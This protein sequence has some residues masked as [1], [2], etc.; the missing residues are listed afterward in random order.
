MPSLPNNS[1]MNNNAYPTAIYNSMI[2]PIVPYGIKGAIWYQG[3]S[4]GGEGDEYFHKMQALIG[5][6]RKIWNEGDFPFYFVQ[7]ANFQDATNNPMGGDGWARVRMAQTKS[8]SIPNTGMAVIYDIGDR[9]DIHPH[10]K[11]NVGERLA[12]WALRDNYGKSDLVVSGPLFKSLQVNGDKLRIT[13]DSVGPGLMV[14][15]K[16]G[17]E[18]TVEAPDGKLAR[19]AIAGEDHNWVWADAVIDGATVVLEPAGGEAGGG[20]VRVFAEPGRCKSLQ[21]GGV[22]GLAISDRRLGGWEAGQVTCL[23]CWRC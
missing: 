20:A 12:L 16:V 2:H 21:Q 8:L 11:F 22:A 23:P 10:N 18:P 19:F 15:K 17:R 1:P 4:N 3:E 13:F 7:L 14:G 5:G 9:K 6:W